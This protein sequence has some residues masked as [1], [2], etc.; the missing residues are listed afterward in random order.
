MYG[1]WVNALAIA[2]GG[3][4]G[5]LLRGGI[6]ERFKQVVSQALGLCV[7]II[8]IS[9]AIKTQDMLLVIVCLILGTLLGEAL[10]I[11]TGLE[12][13]GELAQK[14]FAKGDSR[15]AEGF[16]SATLLF[17][18]GAMAV[19]GSLQAGLTGDGSTLVAKSALDGVT[20]VIFASSLGPGVLLSAAPILV[21][22]GAIALLAGSVQGL[23]S[24]EVIGEMAAVG[25]MLIVGLGINML[26]LGNQRMKVGNMLPAMLLPIAY[27]PMM[28]WVQSLMK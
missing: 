9:G 3:A 7:L 4:L 28:N 2:V 17:C 16:V 27:I 19:V 5:L 18:V 13:L 25:S 12:R 10:K 23:L 11:E 15:F 22:Q 20:S 6:S 21:Y 14:R 8:G 26:G 24:P 1:V